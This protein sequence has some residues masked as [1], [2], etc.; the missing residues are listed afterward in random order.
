MNNEIHT[1]PTFT[2]QISFSRLEIQI[3]IPLVVVFG[4]KK[5]CLISWH[6]AFRVNLCEPPNQ[7]KMSSTDLLARRLNELIIDEQYT[8]P[9]HQ[10]DDELA[11]EFDRALRFSN[12]LMPMTVTITTPG[13]K[14][15]PP[16]QQ[17]A[18]SVIE[19]QPSLV[20]VGSIFDP[21]R[22]LEVI[23]RCD[24]PPVVWQ[25]SD[26]P[27]PTIDWMKILQFNY[28]K[29]YGEI[30]HVY[31]VVTAT[32][33]HWR[34]V[35]AIGKELISSAY[36][37]FNC[38]PIS[39][40]QEDMEGYRGPS[41]SSRE[42]ETRKQVWKVKKEVWEAVIEFAHSDLQQSLN[43]LMLPGGSLDTALLNEECNGLFQPWEESLETISRCNG[44][45]HT[46][47]LPNPFDPVLLEG[48][49]MADLRSSSDF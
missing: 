12:D 47:E 20:T 49:T 45:E 40:L 6:K 26:F 14:S 7:S 42:F 24:C 30:L 2:P 27:W 32:T 18:K 48:M 19:S 34:A 5:S 3:E 17:Q 37:I 16:C 29:P 8:I 13:R 41:R 31:Q 4:T 25:A 15:Q 28:S 23:D 21:P 46:Q 22:F 9:S 10:A 43:E 39:L 44:V 38:P 33:I 11:T 1:F 36:L 35:L